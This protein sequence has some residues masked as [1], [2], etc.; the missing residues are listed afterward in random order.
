MATST[1]TTT[2]NAASGSTS[3][4]TAPSRPPLA[5]AHANSVTWRLRPRSSSR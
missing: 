4:S 1:G 3:S 2:S 5:D